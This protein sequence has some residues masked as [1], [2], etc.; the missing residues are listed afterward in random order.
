MNAPANIE[1]APTALEQSI[2]DICAAHGLAHLGIGL[3]IPNDEHGAGWSVQAQRWVGDEPV[4]CWSGSGPSISAAL[5][6][7]LAQLPPVAELADE[8]LQVA[9]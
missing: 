4:G 7:A 3:L 9:A 6:D 5:A 2:R 8:A 1:T